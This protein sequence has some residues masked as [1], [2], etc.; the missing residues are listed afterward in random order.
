VPKIIGIDLG[1]TNS[2]VAVLD[3]DTGHVIHNQEGGRTTPSIV[4]WNAQGDI[5]VGA[6][7]K[8][9]A[10]TNPQSTLLAIK[11]LLGR[12][13]RSPE[14]EY[15]RRVMP[16]EIV[17]AENGDAW[18]RVQGKDLSPQEVSASVLEKMK[19]VAEE[20]LGEEVT[21]AIVTVP[22]YFDDVQRQATKDAGAIAGLK[23]RQILNEPTAAAL[24]FGV[25]QQ[26]DQRVAVFDLGGG[27]F[28]V[29]ILAIESGVFQV[30]ATNGDTLL[31]GDDFDRK[32]IDLLVREFKAQTRTDLEGDAVALQR[33]KEA[34]ERAKIELSSALVTDVNLP[35]LSVGPSGPLHL[36][37]EIKRS[38]LEL[39]CKDLLTRLEGPCRQALS[40]AKLDAKDI[41]QV[42]LVGGMT[43]MPAVQERVEQI[44]GKKPS[45]GVNPDEI[46]AMGAAIQSA[47]MGGELR[48]VILLDV[49]PHAMGIK[50]A[51]DKISVIIPRNTTVPTREAKVFSTTE[52]DQEFVA[53]EV[54][55]GEGQQASRNRLL[56]RF[57]L[58][59][60][61]R[62]PAGHV[63]VEVSFTMDADGILHVA[64]TEMTSGKAT[65]I[66]IQASSG[67]DSGEVERLSGKHASDRSQGR[68]GMG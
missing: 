26:K 6:A 8:R 27:T 68:A 58:G 17:E 67:L 37:R 4:A 18:V 60:L 65:S 43:R 55:Q 19:R 51:G 33:L 12:R 57:V 53:I 47:I 56:G 15:L 61:P 62:R 25:H 40:D 42:V 48:E 35:F 10:V 32:L 44:F 21:E 9:Q 64:A 38:E 66:T 16:Y 45:K 36:Q 59:D 46:V 7:A 34:S 54:V 24:A 63:R 39:L 3:G 22:A 14:V 52:D 2:C 28:D 13:F 49:T 31:G 41:D 29:S 20:Y 1:T 30:L 11:R 23:V 5:I 50:V